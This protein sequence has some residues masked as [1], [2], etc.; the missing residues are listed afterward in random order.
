MASAGIR[1]VRKVFGS[2]PVIRRV[3]I[4]IVHAEFAATAGQPG[5]GTPILPRLIAGKGERSNA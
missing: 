1:D 2:T 4:S 5:R 3:D